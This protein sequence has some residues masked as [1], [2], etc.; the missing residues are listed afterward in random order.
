M[1][2]RQQSLGCL[3]SPDTVS[4]AR[5]AQRAQAA[6]KA[7]AKP[8]LLVLY[9]SQTGTGQEIAVSIGTEAA[10]HGCTSKVGP[11]QTQAARR[12]LS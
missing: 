1:R 6:A 3:C 9:A 4:C 12:R 5:R 7:A 8:S 11:L 2:G 10:Q